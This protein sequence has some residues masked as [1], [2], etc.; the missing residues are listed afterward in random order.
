[1]GKIKINKTIIEEVEYLPCLKC[2][3]ENIEFVCYSVGE[4]HSASGKCSEC[5]NEVKIDKDDFDIK[6][7]ILI[8]K[9]NKFN[10]PNNVAYLSPEEMLDEVASE[11]MININ[12]MVTTK[13]LVNIAMQRYAKQ[14]VERQFK[15]NEEINTNFYQNLEELQN[16]FRIKVQRLLLDEKPISV[17]ES[18]GSIN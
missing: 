3:G 15:I 11:N 8:E 13:R 18:N 6:M 5:S 7:E 9:W 1:M 16:E 4:H 17:T 14:E 12:Q 2:G 10:D